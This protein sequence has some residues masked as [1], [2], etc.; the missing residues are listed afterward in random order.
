MDHR[1]RRVTLKLKYSISLFRSLPLGTGLARSIRRIVSAR[2]EELAHLHPAYS[3]IEDV[4]GLPRVLLIGDSIS[5]GY[6]LAVR[7]ALKGKVNVHRPP[8]NCGS[9]VKGVANLERWL[10][11][12]NWN[13]I[14]INFGLHDVVRLERGAVVPAD[15]YSANLRNMAQTLKAT[16]ARLLWASTTPVPRLAPVPLGDMAY[17]E[18][19]GEKLLGYVEQDIAKYNEAASKVMLE[20]GIETVDL[21]NYVL[22][23]RDDL[24]VPQDIHFTRRGYSAL[25][26]QV[27]EAVRKRLLTRK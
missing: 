20:C 1:A 7:R 15:Q 21:Y 5:I 12:G 13:L 27:A 25:G 23:I 18:P 3:P 24:Q 2:P 19:E 10:G 22:P 17:L 4:P 16:Q 11:N 8:E 9:T 14:L 6:T 26:A